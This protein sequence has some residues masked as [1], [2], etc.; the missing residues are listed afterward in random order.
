MAYNFQTLFMSP[1]LVS[2]QCAK[3]EA[4]NLNKVFFFFPP[5]RYVIFWCI[6]GL[7]E[8]IIVVWKIT[9]FCTSWPSKLPD[10]QLVMRDKGV[11][12]TYCRMNCTFAL[13]LGYSF[14]ILILISQVTYVKQMWETFYLSV[15]VLTLNC[16]LL[17]P[18]WHQ[19]Q[20]N[21]NLLKD[22]DYN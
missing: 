9:S 16:F 20:S 17:D 14:L 21:P 3:L 18:A 12:L 2:A 5:I 13:P 4:W 11:N 19:N 7:F 10:Q 22:P 1:R 8:Q 15:P 6:S